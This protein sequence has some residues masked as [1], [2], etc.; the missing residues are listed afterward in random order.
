[1]SFYENNKKNVVYIIL[2]PDLML[3]RE[4]KT[5]TIETMTEIIEAIIIGHRIEY[6]FRF[7]NENGPFI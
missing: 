6:Q 5:M 7:M 3:E 4:Q 2:H 1:M